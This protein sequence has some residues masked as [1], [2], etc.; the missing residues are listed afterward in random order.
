MEDYFSQL[1]DHNAPLCE[2]QHT[3]GSCY[4]FFQ[5]QL[6]QIVNIYSVVVL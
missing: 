2:Q 1:N 6:P 3:H 4:I 5:I